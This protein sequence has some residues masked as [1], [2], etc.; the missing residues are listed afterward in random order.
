[1]SVAGSRFAT[2]TTFRPTERLGPVVLGDPGDHGPRL[3]RQTDGELQ[4]LPGLRHRLR[5]DDLGDPEIEALELVDRDARGA[6][7]A[8]AAPTGAPAAAAGPSCRS[9]GRARTA[10]ATGPRSVA[11][12]ADDGVRE[13]RR[14]VSP[15]AARIRAA[16]SGTNGSR[17]MPRYRSAS[18]RVTSTAASRALLR[19]IL[20]QRPRPGGIDVPVHRADEAPDLHQGARGPRS[21]PSRRRPRSSSRRPARRSPPPP[22]RRRRRLRAC[23]RSSPASS[24]R[25]RPGCRGRWRDPR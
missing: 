22:P 18:A 7:P 6:F 15:T 17:T 3:V 10:A 8:G 14:R 25:G 5:R 4:E 16:A 9:A 11:A 19:R 24:S 21:R 13:H 20:R 1:M 12:A 23:G 2:T